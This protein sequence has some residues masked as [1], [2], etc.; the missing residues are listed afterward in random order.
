MNKSLVIWDIG[1][2][3]EHKGI[4]AMNSRLQ[5]IAG[6]IALG[7]ASSMSKHGGKNS[8]LGFKELTWDEI[9]S[10]Q[11]KPN[12]F[13]HGISIFPIVNRSM[14]YSISTE[15]KIK[16][17]L[18]YLKSNNMSVSG[19]P[20]NQMLEQQGLTPDQGVYMSKSVGYVSEYADP[21]YAII[22]IPEN[23]M[24]YLKIDELV[25][26]DP[27][28]VGGYSIDVLEQHIQSISKHQGFRDLL[29][30]VFQRYVEKNPNELIPIDEDTY[31]CMLDEGIEH[32]TMRDVFLSECGD[33]N[34][35]SRMFDMCG[36]ARVDLTIGRRINE[37]GFTNEELRQIEEWVKNGEIQID[38]FFMP[39]SVMNRIPVKSLYKVRS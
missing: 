8:P 22:E 16:A 25:L 33:Y 9:G 18:E 20:G 29:I 36:D 27:V 15:D 3:T 5:V 37:E 38:V 26:G 13:W 34:N 6:A 39:S 10:I 14:T 17:T 4:E 7:L 11:L 1:Q 32:P 35:F 23:K 24:Q 2:E 12:Q 21:L 19:H 30:D 28:F 31:E